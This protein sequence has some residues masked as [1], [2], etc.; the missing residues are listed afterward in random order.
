VDVKAWLRDNKYGVAAAGIGASVGAVVWWRRRQAATVGGGVGGSPS[1][2]GYIA[3]PA[4]ANTT[5]TDVANWVGQALGQYSDS[6][7]AYEK[8][9]TD[10]VAQLKQI[11]G[12]QPGPTPAPTPA[13]IP[14]PG[15]G[16][17]VPGRRF[18]RV[19][20]YPKGVY[21]PV[22]DWSSTLTGIASHEKTTVPNLLKLNPTVHN[23]NLIY[24][25]QKIYTS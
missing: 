9:L 22:N 19:T 14:S 7:A 25:G 24:T 20:P 13:P 6:L 5:G 16:T 3:N 11:I 8:S 2:A 21:R 15:T 17:P 12:Q 1:S 23:P 4:N 10:E 18:V